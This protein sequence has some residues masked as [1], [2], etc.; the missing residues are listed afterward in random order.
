MITVV[1]MFYLKFIAL[2]SSQKK[3]L[4]RKGYR[5]KINLFY[6]IQ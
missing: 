5:W 6:Y 2:S 3:L 4:D 1:E